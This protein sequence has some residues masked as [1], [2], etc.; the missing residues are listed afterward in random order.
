MVVDSGIVYILQQP[1]KN[2]TDKKSEQIQ[3]NLKYDPGSNRSVFLDTQIDVLSVHQGCTKITLL[4]HGPGILCHGADKDG[5]ELH[6]LPINEKKSKW[7]TFNK[8]G[9]RQQSEAFSYYPFQ[10]RVNGQI[11]LGYFYLTPYRLLKEKS[12][13]YTA[14]YVHYKFDSNLTNA[15]MQN[16]GNL[17]DSKIGQATEIPVKYF[18]NICQ[19][20]H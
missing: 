8:G 11:H 19:D 17:Y 6:F 10:P 9:R 12:C 18:K 20:E 1:L 14:I 5:K 16:K 7:I 13:S 2:D 4:E 3:Y 15:E